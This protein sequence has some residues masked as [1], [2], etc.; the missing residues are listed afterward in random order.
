MERI[1]NLMSAQ[2]TISDLAS[3]YDQMATTGQQMSSGLAISQPSDN[4]YG[5][6]QVVSLNADLSELSGYTSSIN[7]GT[8]WLNTASGA[9]S[10]ID[11]SVQTV[12]ELVVESANGTMSQADLTNAAAEVNQLIDSVKSSANTTYN[13]NYVF[14]GS[15]TQTAPYQ[16]GSDDT[17]QGNSGSESRTIGPGVSVPVSFDISQVLGNGASSGDG[18]LLDTLRTI[19]TDLQG[20]TGANPSELGTTD[21]QNLDTNLATLGTMEANVG[22]LTDRVSLASNRVQDTQQTDSTELSN[23]QDADI[24]TTAIEYSNEQSAYTAALKAGATIVQSSL[25]NFLQ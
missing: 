5:A 1:T 9:L 3:A 15:A 8:A 25:V 20:G 22:A 24:A 17:Y 14:S 18:G 13:G 12:R 21:L 19:A 23:I 2:Q 7:D 11:N 10:D 4:P 16:S 6:A